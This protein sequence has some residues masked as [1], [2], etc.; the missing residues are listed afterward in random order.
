MTRSLVSL[1]RFSPAAVPCLTPR[2][3]VGKIKGLF[4]GSSTASA[5]TE[6]TS[7]TAAASP[8]H[9]GSAEPEPTE[10]K[11]TPNTI[12]LKMEVKHLSVRPLNFA[13]KRKS[14]D[15]CVP[16]GWDGRAARTEGHVT[17]LA[18]LDATA[19]AR[20]KRAEARNHLEGYLYRLRDLLDGDADTPFMGFSKEE[21]REKLAA[22][23]QET[24]HWLNEESDSAL[25]Y[26][27][28]EPYVIYIQLIPSKQVP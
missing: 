20:M 28:A 1:A 16:F 12:P 17:R 24:M 23:L 4:G 15:R 26:N 27:L 14:R 21:E 13:E 5:E 3:A 18:A 19:L 6:G 2:Y 25:D 11:L 7:E 10:V 9:G 8:T 22:G